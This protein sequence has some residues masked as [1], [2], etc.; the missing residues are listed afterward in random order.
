MKMMVVVGESKCDMNR[1]REATR[2]ERQTCSQLSS[3]T[4]QSGNTSQ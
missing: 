1:R 3:H 2:R 4:L